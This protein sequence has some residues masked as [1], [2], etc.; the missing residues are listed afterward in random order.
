MMGDIGSPAPSGADARERPRAHPF[1]DADSVSLRVCKHV[2]AYTDPNCY[3]DEEGK[4]H[5]LPEYASSSNRFSDSP[6]SGACNRAA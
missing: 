6:E 5:R 2:S 3:A 4:T 1:N